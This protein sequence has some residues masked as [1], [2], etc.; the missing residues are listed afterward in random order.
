MSAAGVIVASTSADDFSGFGEL[1][2][3]VSGRPVDRRR[4]SASVVVEKSA[5]GAAWTTVE[6]LLFAVESQQVVAVSS[7]SVY[8]R[9]R[10]ESLTSP[11][12]FSVD[13]VPSVTAGGSGGGSVAVSDGSTTVDPASSIEFTGATV[14]DGGGGVAQVA[15]GGSQPALPWLTVAPFDYNGTGAP[16]Y[17]CDG[18]DDQVEIQAALDAASGDL[19]VLLLPGHFH[20]TD[21][22]NIPNGGAL[23]GATAG[24]Y[25]DNDFGSGWYEFGN[26]AVIMATMTAPAP[27]IYAGN[28]DTTVSGIQLFTSPGD[29]VIGIDASNDYATVVDCAVQAT[30]GDTQPGITVT[31]SGLALRCYTAFGGGIEATVAIDCSSNGLGVVTADTAITTIHGVQQGGSLTASLDADG[32]TLFNL[33]E[34]ANPQDAATKNYVDTAHVAA[35]VDPTTADAGAIANALI[36]AGLMAAS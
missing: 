25:P 19:P 18:V 6:T 30:N 20:I 7:P 9:V 31:G 1:L 8:V 36:A 3:A 17:V 10:C 21:T 28:G 33:S 5:D 35:F 4:G 13:V 11:W 24:A 23:I 26:Y 12:W 2:V 32:N 29:D 34:P 16:D 27:A 22:I 14:T 15:V